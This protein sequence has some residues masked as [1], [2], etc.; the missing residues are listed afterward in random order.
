MSAVSLLGWTLVVLG[1]VGV[2]P[3]VRQI[4]T[5]KTTAGLSVLGWELACGSILGWTVHGLIRGLTQ[6]LVVNGLI[7]IMAVGIIGAIIKERRLNPVRVWG[8]IA[9]IFGAL[10]AADVFLGSAAFGALVSIPGVAGFIAGL[11]E[12]MRSPSI[13]GVSVLSLSV[14]TLTQVGWLVWGA[15]MHDQGTV[16]ASVVLVLGLGSNVVW[17]ILRA[18]GAVG[19]LGRGAAQAEA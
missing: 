13:G 12:L 17:Y 10:V 14:L 1:I 9:L 5:A 3:Q 7:A 15:L 4:L 6:Q 18:T 19:P 11:I 8:V 16:I 2:T